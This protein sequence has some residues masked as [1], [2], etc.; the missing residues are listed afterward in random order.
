MK[1]KFLITMIFAAVLFASCSK[2]ETD[3]PQTTEREWTII[4]YFNGNN[5]LDNTQAGTSYIIG[6]VQEMEHAGGSEAVTSIVMLSS[7][8]TGG[9]ANYY[10]IEKAENQLPDQVKSI[11][12]EDMGSKDMSDPQTLIN[13][14]KYAKDNYP[15]KRYMLVLNSHGGGWYGV[16]PD[17]ANGSGDMMSLPDLQMAMETGPHFDIVVFHACLMSMTEVAYE[18]KDLAD[19]MVSSEIPMPALSVLGANVWLQEMMNNPAMSSYD[20]SK[21]IVQCVYDNGSFAQKTTHMAVTDLSKMDALGAKVA[22]LGNKLTTEV[23]N[24]WGEVFEAWNETHYICPDFPSFT[25]LREFV[26]KLQ[27]KPGL[28]QINYITQACNDVISAYNDA[29]PFTKC[30]LENNEQP[31]GGLTIHFPQQEQFFDKAEYNNLQF[32]ETNWH[33]FLNIFIENTQG[34]GGQ[35][36]DDE[37][38][39]A[40]AVTYPGFNLSGN[41]YVLVYTVEGGNV[42]LLGYGNTETNGTFEFLI[43]GITQTTDFAFEA[44]DDAN[45]NEQLD[46]G[47]GYGFWDG[48]GNNQWDDLLTGQP[49]NIYEGINIVLTTFNGEK[50]IPDQHENISLKD[51]KL[52][53]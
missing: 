7:L 28:S 5:N 52:F 37:V 6:D 1:A 49:G 48:N 2:D 22:N 23:G 44:Y 11:L 29:I 51:I 10:K 20:V 24:N 33:N 35:V 9:N 53:D 3:E 47:E 41:T 25:D 14:I 27:Q 42:N 45:G 40:G 31:Y 34:G 16:S 13:F 4:G 50:A 38:G 12:L 17:E 19:Y 32:K 46:F 18:I 26:K 39:I 36:G 15:A 30:Y 8:K 43:T 21:K